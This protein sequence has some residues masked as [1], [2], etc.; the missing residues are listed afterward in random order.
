L[1]LTPWLRALL[2]G[3]DN[4]A[5]I[6]LVGSRM[7]DGYWPFFPWFFV[8]AFGFL[9]AD[10]RIRL[11]EPSWL[12]T[13]LGIAGMTAMG[14]AL[15]AGAFEIHLDEG[16]LWGSTI[17]QPSLGF[18]GGLTGFFCMLIALSEWIASRLTFSPYGLVQSFS[19]GV[20]W[21]YLFHVSIADRL[22]A[23]VSPRVPAWWAIV[24]Y[25]GLMAIACWG[26]GALSLHL[27]GKR[28]RVVLAKAA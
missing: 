6:L 21:I 18:I 26:V 5:T 24:F 10:L 25:P 19:K 2:A 7:E 27:G 8:V 23:W 13:A 3:K 20:L 12:P 28:I 9:V 11:K 16:H 14:A 1:I 4:L 15:W 22:G 17:F